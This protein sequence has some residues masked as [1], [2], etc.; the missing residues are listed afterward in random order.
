[1]NVSTIMGPG[2]GW[3]VGDTGLDQ[4]LELMDAHG[5]RHLAVLE[6]GELIGV[7]SDLDLLQ[8][9]GGLPSRVH[10]CRGPAISGRLPRRVSDVMR[11]PVATIGPED[12]IDVALGE[13]LGRHID[14]LPVVED[15]EFV[16]M[17]TDRDVLGGYT[18]GRLGDGAGTA[19]RQVVAEH[20]TSAPTTIQW[21]TSLGSAIALCRSMGVRH[22]PLLQASRLVGIVSERD[23]RRA[24]GCGRHEDMPVGDIVTMEP[25]TV[26]PGTS[27]SEAAQLMCEHRI[28]ALPVVDQDECV[29]ILTASDVLEHC[30]DASR[31]QRD[32]AT[33]MQAG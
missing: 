17:L 12:R 7:V 25:L 13:L 29:G 31:D 22:L 10:A 15:G 8:A 20:M 3:V 5:L 4:A 33:G 14:G 23:L 6:G 2:T 26:T 19:R 24:V 30:L 18:E 21:H 32:A 27:L 11:A 9:T 28:S 16:G 1:M